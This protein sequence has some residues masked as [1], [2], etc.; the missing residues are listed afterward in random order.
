VQAAGRSNNGAAN[1]HLRHRQLFRKHNIP[2]ARV[3]PDPSGAVIFA[4][5]IAS[6]GGAG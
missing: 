2:P 3:V 4:I 1:A 6:K 5:I